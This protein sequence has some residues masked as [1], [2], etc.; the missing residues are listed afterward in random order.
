MLI[1]NLKLSFS[2]QEDDKIILQADNGAEIIVPDYLL[3]QFTEH[4]KPVFLSADYQPTPSADDNKKEVL[5]DL[6]GNE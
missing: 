4:N 3:E 5:N 2:R 1:K 6:L